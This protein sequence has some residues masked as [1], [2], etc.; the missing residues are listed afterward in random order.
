MQQPAQKT[1]RLFVKIG[2]K[3]TDQCELL[4]ESHSEAF[5]K[6]MLC[7]KAEHYALP[8]RLEQV[9]SEERDS[10]KPGEPQREE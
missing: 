4:A 1:Y 2:G 7:L 9:H 3:W 10:S 8:I 6:A 5:S